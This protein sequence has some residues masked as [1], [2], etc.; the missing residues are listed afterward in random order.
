[1]PLEI[2]VKS[3]THDTAASYALDDRGVIAPGYLAD[4]NVIDF[5]RLKLLRP[6]VAFDLPT[7]ARRLLQRAEGYVATVKRGEVTFRDGEHTG[8]FPGRLIRGAQ[9]APISQLAAA[10]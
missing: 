10:G 7:G 6:Y 5:N 4:L 8:A 1:V 3:C 2:A 9:P